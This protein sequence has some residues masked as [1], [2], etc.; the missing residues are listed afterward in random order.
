MSRLLRRIIAGSA[1][2]L[3]SAAGGSLSAQH[4]HDHAMTSA[5]A[6]GAETIR[7]PTSCH[8]DTEEE[9]R[10]AVAL[11]HSFWFAGAIGSFEQV[12]ELDPD[13][14]IAHWGIALAHWGN[15][16]A[17]QRNA[18]QLAR[19]RAAV[20]RGLATGAPNERETRYL[21][22]VA[23]LFN[24]NRPETQ[25]NRTLAYENAME[26]LAK[27]YPEDLEARIFYALAISQNHVPG[28]QTYARQLE[29]GAILEPLFAMHPDHPG[30]AHYIIHA[31]DH[32]PLAERALDAAMRYASL[33]PDAPHALHMPSH[34][35]T[36]MGLWQASIDTNKRSAAVASSAGEELH[37]LDYM[38]YAYLQLGRDR[39]A[40]EVVRR[41]EALVGEVDITAV[42][43]T[44]AGAFAIAAI[45]ARYALERRA[46][47]EA[48]ALPV[49]ASE[50]PHTRAMTHFARAV[51]AARSGEPQAATDD[52]T[53]LA[54]LRDQLIARRDDYWAEQVDIQWQ[55]ARAWLRFAEGYA[56][57]GIA[58]LTDAAEA[59]D[60]TDKSAISP[61]PLAPARELLGWMLLESNRPEAALEA[62]RLTME[63]E[64]NR[65]LGLYG[66]GRAA[67]ALED[68]VAAREFY[69]RLLE[70]TADDTDRAEIRH[71]RAF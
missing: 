21:E 36:R 46:F 44:Q 23:E 71:A 13:C 65:F 9:F 22:A 61:G 37:A 41:S 30:L 7:F 58:L 57:A 28:D 38:A 53:K 64:P 18:Q 29:A 51:G 62:F 17:G 56:D 49:Q 11:V 27:A 35:F 16:F 15:P 52:V 14:A 19:G 3:L 32:P 54:A 6:V 45:P 70:V 4:D 42:G 20:E 48:A 63:K 40:R 25:G 68:H 69:A 2:A 55:V 60:R 50:L 39:E 5:E 31:Y 10:R 33:A 34:T 12:L 66:A 24:D 43:A 8:A 47:S 1:C 67:E 59:E 26:A